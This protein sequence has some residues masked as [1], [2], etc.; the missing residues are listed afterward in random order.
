[1]VRFT[2]SLQFESLR[3]REWAISHLMPVLCLVGI[4]ALKPAEAFE[5]MAQAMVAEV[6][7]IVTTLRA[8]GIWIWSDGAVEA[9]LGIGKNDPARIGFV[10]T[11]RQNGN[12]SHSTSPQSLMDLAHWM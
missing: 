5:Q 7:R 6:G 12:L 4:S 9:H 11:A 10:N 2:A 1:M 8:Y 3:E